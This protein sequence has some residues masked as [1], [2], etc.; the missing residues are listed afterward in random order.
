[1]LIEVRCHLYTFHHVP[2][3]YGAQTTGAQMTRCQVY[4]DIMCHVLIEVRFLMYVEVRGSGNTQ[5]SAISADARFRQRQT[6]L[7]YK[8]RFYTRYRYFIEA[9]CQMSSMEVRW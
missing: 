6:H 7:T 2:G 5:R 1:M 9:M 3:I 8:W 4:I